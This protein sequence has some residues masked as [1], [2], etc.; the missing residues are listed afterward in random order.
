[1]QELVVVSFYVL[2]VSQIS[3][4]PFTSLIH[5]THTEPVTKHTH[6]HTHTLHPLR[7]PTLSQ[8]QPQ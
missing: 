5:R 8:P 1:M 2:R 6:A 7:R 3:F 4:E